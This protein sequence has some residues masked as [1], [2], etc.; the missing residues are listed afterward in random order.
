MADVAS[1]NTQ[2]DCAAGQGT[3]FAIRLPIGAIEQRLP[4]NIILQKTQ[5]TPA[6]PLG[7]QCMLK[8]P[9]RPIL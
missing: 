7:Y 1:G 5:M 3:D 4:N 2:P 6:S 8:S 9:I